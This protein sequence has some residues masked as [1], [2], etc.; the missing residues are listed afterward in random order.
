MDFKSIKINFHSLNNITI[1]HD[2]I[3]S[4]S[5]HF[6]IKEK[7][8]HVLFMYFYVFYIWYLLYLYIFAVIKCARFPFMSA[9]CALVFVIHT[10]SGP[11]WNCCWNEHIL[12]LYDFRRLS[13]KEKCEDTLSN[14][15][16]AVH[17]HQN[18]LWKATLLISAGVVVTWRSPQWEGGRE[19][20][21][22]ELWNGGCEKR[23]KA[24]EVV[25]DPPRPPN[26]DE[27][28]RI[29]PN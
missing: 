19:K 29:R 13:N 8:F 20:Q 4:S 22:A 3:F 12:L 24:V 21:T 17:Y 14:A 15:Q 1:T 2:Y 5:S 6:V 26:P 16:R 27:G 11:C 25:G 18:I 23:D 10:Y 9:V 28:N 7:T